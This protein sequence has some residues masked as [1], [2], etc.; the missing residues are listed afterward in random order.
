MGRLQHA[1]SVLHKLLFNNSVPIPFTADPHRPL[2]IYYVPY[3]LLL[4]ISKNAGWESKD[5]SR[6]RGGKKRRR[7]IPGQRLAPNQQADPHL[8]HA[9]NR[10][11]QCR[12][13]KNVD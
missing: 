1:A 2:A 13:G 6:K 8:S 5:L 11:E 10:S 3:F 12:L 4:S 7:K 9:S